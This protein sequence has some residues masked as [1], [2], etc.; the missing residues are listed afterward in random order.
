MAR[1]NAAPSAPSALFASSPALSK[2]RKVDRHLTPITDQDDVLQRIMLISTATS[3]AT[4]S[5]PPQSIQNTQNTETRVRSISTFS[6]SPSSRQ[7]SPWTTPRPSPPPPYSAT[8]LVLSTFPLPE[9]SVPTIHSLD[10]VYASHDVPHQSSRWD[11]LISRFN[12]LYSS[13]PISFIARSPGRVNLIGEHIDYSWFPVMPMAMAHDV[14]VAISTIPSDDPAADGRIILSNSQPL[15]YPTRVFNTRTFSDPFFEIPIGP[16]NNIDWSAYFLAGLKGALTFSKLCSSETLPLPTMRILIDGE[17]PTCA[18]LSAS[19]ALVCAVLVSLLNVITTAPIEKSFLLNSAVI[20]ERVLGVNSGGMD[21]AA[22]VYGVRDNALLVDFRP[23]VIAR[24]VH[25]LSTVPRLRF[26]LANSL[27]GASNRT[28][29]GPDLYNVRVVETTLAAEILARRYSVGRLEI[30]DGFGGTLRGFYDKIC[31]QQGW[32]MGDRESEERA[33]KEILNRIRE[34][35]RKENYTLD[36]AADMIGLRKQDMVRKYM[37]RFPIRADRLNFRSRAIHVIEESF[38]VKCFSS[39]LAAENADLRPL[40]DSESSVYFETLGQLLNAS[41]ES[42][43]RNFEVTIPEI[44]DIVRISRSFGASGS[45]ITGTGWGGCVIS[46]VREDY[47]DSVIRG[48]RR[49]Y[50]SVRFPGLSESETCKAVFA[51]NPAN[52]IG[53]A[54]FPEFK[55]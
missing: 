22:C 48:L 51:L 17:I 52:G 21:Q 23:L 42:C 12:A 25:M 28:E 46:L 3:T 30:R 43:S 13:R 54:K 41:H 53:I 1:S 35:F 2:E 6:S 8:S 27:V 32:K 45:R 10:D 19:S 26:V 24:P 4:S 31:E 44:E 16:N 20:S 18:G 38:R 7:H 40:S 47:V 39:L 9:D 50:Y 37:T 36:E 33:V 14:L 5:H 29:S 11:S 34:T 15:K 49:E 55:L